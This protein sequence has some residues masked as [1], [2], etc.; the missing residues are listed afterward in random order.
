MNLIKCLVFIVAGIV[1]ISIISV[2]AEQSNKMTGE[3][4]TK[5]LWEDIKGCDVKA[6]EGYMSPQFQS[7]H[8]DGSRTGKEELELIK[9]LNL[10][11]YTLTNFKTT[12]NETMIVVTY[13]VSVTETIDGR[14]LNSN[15]APRLS[16][17]QKTENGWKL[18][19]HANLKPI[20]K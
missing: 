15:P 5:Q 3:T 8:Q 13:L 19:I 7:I 4:L 16:A 14:Q 11:D 6:I 10:G 2:G 20:E 18:I 17:W 1:L 9:N 12:E